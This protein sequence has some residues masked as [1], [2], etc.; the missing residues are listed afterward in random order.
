M[1]KAPPVLLATHISKV[2]YGY[3]VQ[4]CV[5]GASD[6]FSARTSGKGALRRA[7]KWSC[8]RGTC[9]SLLR[10]CNALQPFAARYAKNGGYVGWS[11]T[12]GCGR[13]FLVGQLKEAHEALLGAHETIQA[14]VPAPIRS[15]DHGK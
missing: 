4:C 12:S 7:K 3:F 13:F 5:C 8:P 15:T 2:E 10:L 1:S 9:G 14:R 11:E 6:G